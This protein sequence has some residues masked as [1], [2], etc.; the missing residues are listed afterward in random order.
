MRVD[1]REKEAVR[2]DFREREAVRVDF[3]ERDWPAGVGA[4]WLAAFFLLP[5]LFL[6]LPA[7]LRCPYPKAS[8][9]FA[10]SGAAF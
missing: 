2:V 8:A 7:S 4:S 9:S 1:F 10:A 6:H 5:L 3:R